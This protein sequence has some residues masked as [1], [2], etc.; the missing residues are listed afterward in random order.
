MV[1]IGENDCSAWTKLAVINFAARFPRGK[2][3]RRNWG[4]K[5]ETSGGATF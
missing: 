2:R 5:R 4:T 3:F 1:R